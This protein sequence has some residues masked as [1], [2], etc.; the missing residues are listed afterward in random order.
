[1]QLAWSDEV[2]E[3]LIK[4]E[5]GFFVK[6]LFRD[7]VLKWQVGNRHHVIQLITSTEY[8]YFVQ[9]EASYSVIKDVYWG[10]AAAHPLMPPERTRLLISVSC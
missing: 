4:P 7:P 1:V 6:L 5:E 2:P 3:N 9:T 8:S 10:P